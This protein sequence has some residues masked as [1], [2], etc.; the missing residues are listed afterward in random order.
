MKLRILGHGCYNIIYSMISI[1]GRFVDARTPSF[2]MM[3]TGIC[4]EKGIRFEATDGK[5]GNFPMWTLG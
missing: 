4:R 5:I 1:C 2:D 3:I